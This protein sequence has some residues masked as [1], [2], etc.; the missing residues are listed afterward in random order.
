M[1]ILKD[2]KNKRKSDFLESKG[3]VKETILEYLPN[4]YKIGMNE[5]YFNA[6]E[7]L[8]YF[9]QGA[10]IDSLM[11]FAL[12]YLP[13][14]TSIMGGG[15]QEFGTVSIGMSVYCA[16]CFVSDVWVMMKFNTFE[17]GAVLSL[18]VCFAAPHFFYFVYSYDII[19]RLTGAMKQR[20][21]AIYRE[22]WVQGDF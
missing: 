12:V 20:D 1:K 15:G 22:A 2:Q 9:I 4:L 8:K 17:F 18:L 6:T 13:L 16:S 14:S 3:A 7:L 21:K 19:A 5:E 10:F 11:I